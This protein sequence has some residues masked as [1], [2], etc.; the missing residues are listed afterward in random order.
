[1]TLLDQHALDELART[2]IDERFKGFLFD[3][4]PLI[5]DLTAHPIHVSDPAVRRPV[6]TIR[7]SAVA[8]NLETMRQYCRQHGADLVPHAKT[9]MSPEL[10]QRQ[11]QAGAAGITVANVAQARL[12]RHYGATEIII[13][14]QVFAAGDLQWITKQSAASPHS[15]ITT[16]VDSVAVVDAMTRGLAGLASARDAKPL[17]VLLEIGY[18]GGRAGVRDHAEAIRVAQAVAD[19]DSLVLVGVEGFE[20]VMPGS[21]RTDRARKII[22]YLDTVRS[23]VTTLQ[24]KR[25]LSASPTVTFGGSKYF[26]AV[27]AT[28]NPAWRSRHNVRLILRSGCYLTHDHGTYAE[29]APAGM[30]TPALELR[31]DVISTPTSGLAIASFGKRDAPFDSGL[32]TL[33]AYARDGSQRPVSGTVTSLDDQHA[34]IEDPNCALRVGDEVILG[35]SHPCTAFDKWSLIP[36][37]DDDGYIVSAV[38]TF[39]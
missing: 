33:L 7:E 8:H 13:A 22:D 18:T 35:I 17:P 2:P 16:V 1:M 14:N 38:Q 26:D 31:A 23:L 19:S 11:L 24:D 3:T 37:I 6:L 20:G 34:Y 21:D 15:S 25:L 5:G 39:F 10:V 29:Q 30:F 32:P 4:P 28:F 12:F 9:T 36:V 27:V